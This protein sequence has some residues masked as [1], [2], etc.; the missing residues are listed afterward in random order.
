M[1][2]KDITPGILAQILEATNASGD[3]ARHPID[4]DI[5]AVALREARKHWDAPNEFQP[6]DLV[7]VARTSAV[8]KQELG[9]GL[10]LRTYE[11]VDEPS[12]TSGVRYAHNMRILILHG[13]GSAQELA[14]HSRDFE[15]ATV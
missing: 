7:R 15:H 12:Q 8:W 6:D 3:K 2:I 1:I 11:T 13:N 9:L 10:V 14:V 5:A 4:P